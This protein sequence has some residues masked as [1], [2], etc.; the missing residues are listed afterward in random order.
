MTTRA[1]VLGGGGVAGIGWET[2]VLIGLADGGVDVTGADLV[3]GTSAGSTVA[4]Q[5]TSGV[6]LEDLFDRQLEPPGRSGE[7]T[8]PFDLASLEQFWIEAVSTASSALELRKAVGAM[9]LETDTVPEAAR[10][11]VIA[12]R[13]PN[14]AW[15]NRP[16]R[17]VAVDAR[18]GEERIFDEGGDVS[19]VDAV[20]ASCAVPGIW[21]PITIDGRRFMDGGIRSVLNAD[22]AVGHDLVLILAPIDEPLPMSDEVSAGMKELEAWSKIRTVRPDE[23][24]V[25][26][27]GS[28]LLHPDTREPSA[29]AGRAQGQALAASV[30]SFWA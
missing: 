28:D 23:A 12:G 24:S 15:P 17:I 9:A 4:A 25:A 2:G 30:R 11:E 16:V 29:R 3:V 20:A 13:L 21:P 19:L 27:F 1:L 26:A 5:I 8:A 14:H 7:L 10:L 18:T 6:S 22:L